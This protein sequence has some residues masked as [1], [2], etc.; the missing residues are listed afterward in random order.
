VSSEK[1]P[2]GGP[3]FSK[4]KTKRLVMQNCKC[5]R[6]YKSLNYLSKERLGFLGIG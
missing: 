5:G 6:N 3:D 2:T 4:D 1:K